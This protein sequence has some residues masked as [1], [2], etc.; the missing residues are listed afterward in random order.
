MSVITTPV[1]RDF[2]F[3]FGCFGLVCVDLECYYP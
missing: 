1:I 2:V 3:Y